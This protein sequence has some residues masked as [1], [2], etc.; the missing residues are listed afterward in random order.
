[1][2]AAALLL[3]VSIDTFCTGLM[4][5]R[6]KRIR[7]MQ[8]KQAEQISDLVNVSAEHD[9]SLNYLDRKVGGK[10]E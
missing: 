1:M 7:D 8:A 6:Y 9:Y 10:D 2:V 3:L 4:L 5:G